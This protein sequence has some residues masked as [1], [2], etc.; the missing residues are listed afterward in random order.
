MKKS[1]VFLL[2]IV[3]W[4]TTS[5][6]WD[7]DGYSVGDFSCDWV[8]TRITSSADYTHD[9]I[10]YFQ[11]D[12]WGSLYPLSTYPQLK[13]EEN[14][15][16]MLMFNPIYDDYMGFDCGVKLID[17]KPILTKR[18]EL[19]TPDLDADFGNDPVYIYQGDIWMGGGFLNIIFKQQLPSI[20]KH[21]VSLVATSLENAEDDEGYVHLEF[22]YNDFDDVTKYYQFSAVSYDLSD[23]GITS[24]TRG[25]RLKL[26][27]AVNGERIIQLDFKE[28]G[29]VPS[30]VS[31]LDTTQPMIE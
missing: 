16:A 2:A 28:T 12:T 11:G 15:R 27:S 31:Q 30:T 6:D 7:D 1:F 3:G 5:C 9:R 24:Q 19:L 14:Q 18:V 17:V 22:R 29:Q 20:H 4:L 13:L 25:I 26:N 21:R 10:S 23:L 8:T